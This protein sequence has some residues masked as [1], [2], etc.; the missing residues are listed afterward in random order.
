MKRARIAG[1]AGFKKERARMLASPLSINRFLDAHRAELE[2]IAFKRRVV[3]LEDFGYR[4]G[5]DATAAFEA[6]FKRF[7]RGLALMLPAGQIRVRTQRLV[8]PPDTVIMSAQRGRSEIVGI[9]AGAANPNAYGKSI[10][11]VGRVRDV[12]FLGLVFSGP[13]S[14]YVAVN[15]RGADR[16]EIADCEAREICL[17]WSYNAGTSYEKATPDNA[18]RNFTIQ[19]CTGQS[20][21]T[22]L[23]FIQLKFARDGVIRN[24]TSKGYLHGIELWGGDANREGA[25]SNPRKCSNV[26]VERCRATDAAMGGVWGAMLSKVEFRDSYAARCHDVGFDFEGSHDCVARNCV[27]E[28]CTNANFAVFFRNRN[29]LYERCHGISSD[30]SRFPFLFK[31]WNSTGRTRENENVIV[32]NCIFECENGIGLV[33][34]DAGAASPF[35]FENNELHSVR[36]DLAFF[37]PGGT[38]T[39]IVANN[40]LTFR[41]THLPDLFG[42]ATGGSETSLV[43]AGRT[44]NRAWGVNQHKNSRITIV[45]GRGAGQSRQIDGNNGSTLKISPRWE[46]VPDRTSVYRIAISAIV[47]GGSTGAEQRV[48]GNTVEAVRSPHFLRAVHIRGEEFN[49]SPRYVV[50]DNRLADFPVAGHVEHRGRNAGTRTVAVFT[51]N[52]VNADAE[53]T[54]DATQSG[55]GGTQ[56]PLVSY[57][58]NTALR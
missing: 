3:T 37:G 26:L 20:R 38:A 53:W 44:G 31:S 11:S 2:R 42:Q 12:R 50:E 40:R 36:I 7:P 57:N 30:A 4:P 22:I 55:N 28:D 48:V 29:I 14:S 32:R 51:G 1:W 15:M 41:N 17:A 34:N 8:V 18:T 10:F 23:P 45:A 43:D 46:V 35:R 56:P 52:R 5:G 9:T 47:M 24:C 19:R 54:M 39:Q 16:V 6:A 27:A 25:P 58:A 13:D 49:A 21:T 33:T